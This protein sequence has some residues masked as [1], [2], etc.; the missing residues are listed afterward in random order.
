MKHEYIAWFKRR[1]VMH[2]PRELE[3]AESEAFT[4][5]VMGRVR[6][7]AESAPVRVIRFPARTVGLVAAAAAVLV[8][9]L[10]LN[11]KPAER[12]EGGLL[13][14]EEASPALLI[15]VLEQLGETLPEADLSAEEE[16]EALMR[17]M[18]EEEFS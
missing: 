18:D 5:S 14:L 3:P 7:S 6:A 17:W 9:I 11:P 12:S 13:H 16:L 8:A 1:I 10:V 2:P 15:S 4:A